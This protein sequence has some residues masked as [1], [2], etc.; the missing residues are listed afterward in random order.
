[1]SESNSEIID[2]PPENVVDHQ[3][4]DD[5]QKSGSNASASKPVRT[6]ARGLQVA[7]AAFLLVAGVV[8][9]GWAYRDLLSSYLP[10]DSVKAL[11]QRVDALDAAN[12]ELTKKLEALVGVTDEIRSQAG[13]AQSAAD[14]LGKQIASL[15]DAGSANAKSIA[16]L[17]TGLNDAQAHLSALESKLQDAAASAG[18]TPANAGAFEQRLNSVEK[19]LDSLKAGGGGN[20]DKAALSQALADLKGKISEGTAF[21][22]EF[23][24]IQRSVPAADGLDVLAKYAPQGVANLKTLQAQLKSAVAQLPKAATAQSSSDKSW[25]AWF[26]NL[27]SDVISIRDQAQPDWPV[28]AQK[29]D[30]F[31]AAGDLAQAQGLFDN[32]PV[33]LPD[34]LKQWHE[35]ATA[36]LQLDAA[37][38]KTSAAVLRQIAARG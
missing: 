16:T 11:A 22:D 27:F 15:K 2:I 18:S 20:I 4:A 14:M 24:R 5:A 29:A 31:L 13:A 1:M 34:G 38:D 21:V 37:F 12:K 32:L 8:A 7:V 9:G 26:M 17:E 33:A 19:D 3:P 28:L 6:P 36:R 25:S 10:S 35:A 30:A 23:G